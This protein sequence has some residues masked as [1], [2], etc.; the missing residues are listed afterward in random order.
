MPVE[1]AFGMLKLRWACLLKR[2]DVSTD[3]APDIIACCIVLHNMCQV[4]KDEVNS[5]WYKE[6]EEMLRGGAP[7]STP[8]D[9]KNQ[10]PAGSSTS[11]TVPNDKDDSDKVVPQEMPAYKLGVQ[12]R[13]TLCRLLYDQERARNAA[14]FGWSGDSDNDADIEF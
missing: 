3:F 6:A 7:L 10:R 1:C 9:V 14:D 2:L 12:Y 11:Y 8:A 5:E 4:H 13:A